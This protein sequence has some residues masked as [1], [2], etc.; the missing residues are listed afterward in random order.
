MQS[1]PNIH[2]EGRGKWKYSNSVPRIPSLFHIY[3]FYSTPNKKKIQKAR[4]FILEYSIFYCFSQQRLRL[5][6]VSNSKVSLLT[7]KIPK[8]KDLWSKTAPIAIS[9]EMPFFLFATH[10]KNNY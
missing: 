9:F 1:D 8:R 3:K 6:T 10:L 2:L 5:M 4:I 7:A